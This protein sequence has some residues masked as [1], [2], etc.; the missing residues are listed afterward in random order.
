MISPVPNSLDTKEHNII[1]F[2]WKKLA[3][4]FI[5]LIW[6]IVMIAMRE[7]SERVGELLRAWGGILFLALIAALPFATAKKPKTKVSPKRRHAERLACAAWYRS[8][9]PF[10][11]PC[12]RPAELSLP[13]R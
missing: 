7:R 10:E 2:A 1:D 4:P 3:A 9:E 5:V 11:L 6:P 8:H 13:N 12:G